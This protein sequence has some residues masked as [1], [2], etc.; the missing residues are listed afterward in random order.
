[1]DTGAEMSEPESAHGKLSTVDREW[2]GG[3]FMGLFVATLLTALGV[4]YVIASL[5]T[6]DFMWHPFAHDLVRHTL[7]SSSL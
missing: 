3:R 7:E 2:T 5:K 4:I 6:G 1:M